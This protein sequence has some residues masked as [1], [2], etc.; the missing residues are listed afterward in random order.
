[1][2]GRKASPYPSTMSFDNAFC[3]KQLPPWSSFTLMLLL[4]FLYCC[5]FKRICTIRSVFY[6]ISLSSSCKNSI[7]QLRHFIIGWRCTFLRAAPILLAYQTFRYTV[8][9]GFSHA[10]RNPSYMY[11]MVLV[12]YKVNYHHKLVRNYS[13]ITNHEMNNK[14]LKFLIKGFDGF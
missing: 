14:S 3:Y 11:S 4:F 9:I 8:C 1:M 7:P 13:N 2:I 12:G 6:M 5:D 10:V